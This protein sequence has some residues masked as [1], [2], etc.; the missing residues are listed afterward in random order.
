VPVLV[1]IPVAQHVDTMDGGC[2]ARFFDGENFEGDQLTLVGPADLPNMNFNRRYYWGGLDSVIV[3]PKARVAIYDA[4]DYR[5]RTATL[6]PGD[7]IKNLDDRKLGLFEDIES[8]KI[9][10]TQ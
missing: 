3:G 9:T 6:N 4:E 10:C 5:N 1:L 2:W 7:R 8:V